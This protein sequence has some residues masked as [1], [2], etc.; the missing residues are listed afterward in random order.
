MKEM[1]VDTPKPMV[2]VGDIPVVQH[3][4]NIFEKYDKFE[5]IIC[6][7]YLSNVLEEYFA[8]FN[9]VK[10]IFTGE[11][12]NTGGRVYKC[13]D[14][15]DE[16]FIVTY[17]DGLANVNIQ[18]LV[19]F[20]HSHNKIGT[21]TVAKPVSRF[22]IVDFNS[23]YEVLNFIEKPKL[24]NYINIGFM[25]FKNDFL[26]YLN[27]NSTLESNP[28]KNLAR[29][30]NLCAFIH[31][32]Y[33]E[34]MDTYREYL[35]MNKLWNTGN[36]LDF[37]YL[38]FYYE[39]NIITGG[40]GYIGSKFVE[41]YLNNYE[42]KV[43]DT[44]YFD[45]Y[46]NKNVSVIK[47]DIREIKTEDLIDID[48]II[49]MSEL[50]NDPLGNLNEKITFEI[51]H[52]ATVKL[53][54][55]ANNSEIKKFIYMSS[56]SV[57]GI[58]DSHSDENSDAKPLTAYAKAKILN[59][60]YILNNNLN[61][62]T[63]ILRNATVFGHSP[64][65]R[66]DLVINDL[67]FNAL[68]NN[69]LELISDGTPKRPFIHV[70]DLVKILTLFIE[71]PKNLDKEIFNIGHESLNYSI[72]NVAEIIG[73]KL[74]ISQIHYGKKDLDQ[75]SYLVNFN[76]FDKIFKYNFEFDLDKGIQD[77]INNYENT[78][79]SINQKRIRKINYLLEE[80]LLDKNLYWI[81]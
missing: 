7:G 9:N 57:Y 51:N 76:K 38:I 30:N 5:F 55:L 49:H 4:I 78:E 60:D 12:T 77:L 64:N 72:K 59:E 44:T 36:A 28:I 2:M 67:V 3:L 54:N 13:K 63:V 80:K 53:L 22:G 34:P 29:D 27:E 21:I 47:K 41:T 61:F 31:E 46:T 79:N 15:L 24:D 1:T 42:I 32:G 40:C 37:R 74:N 39:K 35:N 69:K 71:S 73:D 20:H 43:F 33:F 48:V 65:L 66:L 11:S 45:S 62:E 25:V 70:K 19:D 50:S 58:S 56:C 6:S 23:N 68:R 17:G 8:S 75:R 52:K 81:N 14:I 16:E 18:K 26:N 10:V